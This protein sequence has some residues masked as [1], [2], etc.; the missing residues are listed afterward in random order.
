MSSPETSDSSTRGLRIVGV[1]TLTVLAGLLLAALLLALL[2]FF[3]VRFGAAILAHVER[4]EEIVDD[5]AEARLIFDQPL[6]PIEI[7]AGASLDQRAP[8]STIFFAAGGGVWPVRRSRTISAT[9]SS[10]GASARSVMSSNLPRWKRSSSMAERFLATPDMRRDADRLD[11][12][13]L[14]R[15]EHGARLL[16]AGHQL[17][18]HH[19]VVAGELERDRVGVAA[20]DRGIAPGELSRRLGQ[21]RFAADDAGALGREGDLELGLAGDRAQASR[22]RPLERLGRRFL[23]RISRLDVR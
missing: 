23:R 12:G 17:A 21:A 19:R 3:F 2:A 16:P 5:V 6:E 11:A 9:A 8:Q 15:L 18:V 13:L 10:I 20:H 7:A 1:G 14:D 22:D 4:V